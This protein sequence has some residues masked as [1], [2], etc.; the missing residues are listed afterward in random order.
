V[1]SADVLPDLQ[2]EIWEIFV[3][4]TLKEYIVHLLDASRKHGDLILGGSP[5][6]GLALFRAAQGF[7]AMNGRDFVKPEDIK[8]LFPFVFGHRLLLHPDA[9]LRG[10]TVLNVMDD[11][12]Q[13]RL[14]I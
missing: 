4:E 8:Y 3:D 12:I 1:T 9:E 11:L 7:A 14:L 6:A 5:R 10:R 2:R 13:I